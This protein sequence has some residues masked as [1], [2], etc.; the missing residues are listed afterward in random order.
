MN[1]GRKAICCEVCW[2]FLLLMTREFIMFFKNLF[3][4]SPVIE[5]VQGARFPPGR[6]NDDR[7]TPPEQV[8][9]ERQPQQP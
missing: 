1:F 5:T 8:S 9:L 3:M 7:Q 6:K 4:K 2:E